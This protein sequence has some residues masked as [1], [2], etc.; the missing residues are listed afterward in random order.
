MKR[1]VYGT[2]REEG[3]RKNETRSGQLENGNLING[4]HSSDV[5]LFSL[6]SR[7]LAAGAGYHPLKA[8]SADRSHLERQAQL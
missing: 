4:T 3:R 8:E 7:E 2:V 5:S 6:F 1:E